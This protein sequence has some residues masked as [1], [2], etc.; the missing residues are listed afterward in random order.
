MRFPLRT[1]HALERLEI[2]W[3]DVGLDAL[4]G[5]AAERVRGALRFASHDEV[6]LEIRR[7]SSGLRIAGR[8]REQTQRS[9]NTHQTSHRRG[10]INFGLIASVDALFQQ[11]SPYDHG[12]NFA[13]ALENIQ[14]AR[15]GQ[16]AA[17]RI[18]HRKAVAAMDLQRVVCGSP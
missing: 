10:S 16:N 3:R 7:V 13:R 15:I 4:P 2:A 11:S 18:L 8:E 12:L 14:D 6:A 1:R 17:D 9:K 5:A